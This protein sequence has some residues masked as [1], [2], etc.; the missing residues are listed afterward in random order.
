MHNVSQD[1]RG[2]APILIILIL[3]F[4]AI[5]G[6]AGWRIWDVSK[7][8]SKASSS[9][10][11]QKIETS[12]ETP[13]TTLERVSTASDSYSVSLPRGWAHSTCEDTDILFLAPSEELLGACNS[14]NFGAISI[15]RNAGDTRAEGDPTSDPTATEVSVTSVT[16]DR[17]PATKTSYTVGG[18]EA[19]VPVGTR[20]VRYQIF[21]EGNTYTL[22]TSQSP[23]GPSFIEEL[24]GIVRTFR[25]SD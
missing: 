11:S 2:L 23:G 15:S 25:F 4:L 13:P 24:D 3:L 6:L 9:S 14:G 21:Y 12:D 19:I 10:S 22:G 16:I 7:S 18:E 20:F 8:E 17:Q 5:A 1:S